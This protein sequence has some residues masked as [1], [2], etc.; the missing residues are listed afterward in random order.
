MTE[1]NNT[2]WLV[3]YN[4]KHLNCKNC[5]VKLKNKSMISVRKNKYCIPCAIILNIVTKSQLFKLGFRPPKNTL[6]KTIENKI[7]R[8]S[9]RKIPALR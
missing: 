5:S 6:N 3:E 1:I 7:K 4:Q 9:T 2:T 8:L